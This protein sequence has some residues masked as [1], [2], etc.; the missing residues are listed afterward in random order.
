MENVKDKELNNQN[1]NTENKP[2][3]DNNSETEKVEKELSPREHLGDD[4]ILKVDDLTISFK[5]PKI[6][7]HKE[8]IP[9]MTA[10]WMTKPKNTIENFETNKR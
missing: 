2:E 4:L 3:T 5:T 8:K 10:S 1:L 9:I 7:L 6:W